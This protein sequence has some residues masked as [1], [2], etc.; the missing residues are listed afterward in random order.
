[1][2][3]ARTDRIARTS[4]LVTA[5]VLAGGLTACGDSSSGSAAPKANFC[6][7]FDHLGGDTSPRRA[8]DELSKVG[9]P[10]DIGSSARHGFEVLVDHLRDLPDGTQPRRITQMVQGLNARDAA[11]VRDF[12]SY[13]AS[14]C[15]G[16]PSDSSS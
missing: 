10:A 8:A 3:E 15:Q 5:M 12:I 7:T 9:T 14:E 2:P 6:Q 13:Y 4:L 16:L 11:D 1:M